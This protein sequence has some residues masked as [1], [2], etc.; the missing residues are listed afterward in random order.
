MSEA[1]KELRNFDDIH[2]KL[3]NRMIY[4]HWT[5][6]SGDPREKTLID[7]IDTELQERKMGTTSTPIYDADFHNGDS[8]TQYETY[9]YEGVRVGA[10]SY[11]NE[12]LIK[13]ANAIK[14]NGDEIISG[15]PGGLTRFGNALEEEIRRLIQE[16][17]HRMAISG[18]SMD[19]PSKDGVREI[20]KEEIN[21]K[22]KKIM[23]VS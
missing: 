1:F 7:A 8:Y 5:W 2:L 4:D 15:S 14:Y 16:E 19:P 13:G 17:V 22:L 11:N 9:N 18:N 21:N 6:D 3:L 20:A 23:D 10:G 12:M